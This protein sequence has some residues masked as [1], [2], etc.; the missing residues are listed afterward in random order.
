MGIYFQI[1]FA[2]TVYNITY[3]LSLKVSEDLIEMAGKVNGIHAER[4]R[5]RP[6]QEEGSSFVLC[7]PHRLST[8]R[9][10]EKMTNKTSRRQIE[11]S[12]FPVFWLKLNVAFVFI[13]LISDT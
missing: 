4:V 8:K 2:M 10:R 3:I 7:F 1:I 9:K 13:N 11:D 12:P 5:E 6:A